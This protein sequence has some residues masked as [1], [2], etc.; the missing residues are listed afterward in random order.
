MPPQWEAVG[1]PAHLRVT[2]QASAG[3][4]RS[5]QHIVAPPTSPNQQA[6]GN[7]GGGGMLTAVRRT[8][9]R[10]AGGSREGDAEIEDGGDFVVP[11]HWKAW[12][13]DGRVFAQEKIER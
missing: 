5:H 7:S 1:N 12:I 9:G 13:K 2:A 6:Q 10:F 4:S 3:S 11:E 8:L